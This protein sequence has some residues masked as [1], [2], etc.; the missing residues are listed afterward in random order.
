MLSAWA[1][2]KGLHVLGTGD[3]THP[4]WR[5]ELEEALEPDSASGLYR[6]KDPRGLTREL[7]WLEGYEL[8]GRTLFMLQA[9]I[10]SI[11]KRGGKVRKVHNLVYVPTLEA[12][13]T[14]SEKL[15]AIGNVESDGRPILGLDSRNLLELVLELHPLA[16]LVP[17]HI[18]T[19]W[20][21]LF[22]SKSGFDSLEE[23]FGDLS[24]HVFAMETGL[25]SDPEM[26]WL[27]SALDRIALISNSDAHSGEKLGRE[28]NLFSGER[29][30]EGVY[31]ALR[32]EALGHKL[33]ATL[34]FFPEEGKYHLDGHRKCGV[35]MEPGETLARD[36]R[37]PV[38]GKPLTVGV[39]NRVLTLADRDVPK[40]PPQAAGFES[41]IPLQE[42]ISEVVGTGPATKK[43]RA[44]YARCV[45]R[46]GPELHVLRDA[47]LEDVARISPPLAEALAR[48]RRGEVIRQP[49]FDGQFGVIR[50]FS[51]RERKELHQG[52]FLSAA[53]TAAPATPSR[54]T[55]D[56]A[57][58]APDM[59][60]QTSQAPESSGVVPP[61]AAPALGS[62][63]ASQQAAVA[64]GPGP[65]LVKAGPGS[66]KTHTLLA[67]VA[68]LIEEGVS[69]RRI[70]VVTFTRKAAQELSDRLLARFGELAALP[71]A[72]TLHA[73]AYE[74]WKNAYQDAPVVL[75]EDAARRVFAEANAAESATARELRDAFDRIALARERR[76]APAGTAEEDADEALARW[77]HNFV[78]H[79]ESWNLADYTDLLEFWLEQIEHGIYPRPYVHVLVDEAQDLSRLQIEL[80]RAIVTAQADAQ[81]AVEL[82]AE[83]VIPGRGLFAIGDPDQ[84]I[85]GFR[86]ALPDVATALREIWPHLDVRALERNYRSVQP[87]LDLAA[88][89]L[90]H[91]APLHAHRGVGPALLRLFE[92]PSAES[93]AAWIAERIR[94][95]LGP[96]SHSLADGQTDDE[97]ATLL[98][99]AFSP[100]DI[101]V[102]V[103]TRA[104]IPPLKRVLD[105]MG[106]PVAAPEQETF[107]EDPRVAAILDAAGALFG[108]TR[109]ADA[110]CVDD[111]GDHAPT[112]CAHELPANG[113]RAERDAHGARGDVPPVGTR[114]RDETAKPLPCPDDVLTRGPKAIAAYM[115][116]VPPFDQLFWKSAAFK[117]LVEAFREQG[118]WLGLLNWVHLQS[119]LEHVRRAGEQVQIMTMH[120][121]KG[122]EFRAVFLPALEDGLVPFAG[123]GLAAAPAVAGPDDLAVIPEA[124][125][126]EE[127]RLFYVALTRAKEALFLS[128]AG[129]R[130]LYGRTR[131][132]PAS[133]FLA[134]LVATGLVRRSTLAPKTRTTQ[135]RLSLMD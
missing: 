58:D 55:A 94:R 96:T 27:L 12:A 135:Q 89:S 21:S 26:N 53:P 115:E 69:P 68:R 36:G 125:L 65:V 2:V 118:G 33:Q 105:R 70:L 127:R 66:G 35:A 20:F 31:R 87:V 32:G 54:P 122:L 112:A 108:L 24:Q 45:T 77:R 91:P 119:S 34:E 132:L 59:A 52:T 129:A 95:L 46:L 130:T 11:Y 128:R 37:C 71:R 120:A 22:G 111:A 72:D 61:D 99:K 100:G 103:R 41:L 90:D 81:L 88:T 93:E 51:E 1:L 47:P 60:P 126:A 106:L 49:G 40:K 116:D 86:G 50:V 124:A 28:C 83:P 44:L 43:V 19:P 75:A 114:L 39:L 134:P 17:A 48:M 62:L 123:P 14:L 23:C 67:R 84:S 80:V 8:A 133:R 30:Y 85:Y 121:A 9:E 74:V 79:K 25:S 76:E 4:A 63:D 6:L 98:A 107:W 110:P 109:K 113:A 29:S 73:L 15:A 97:F 102:L 57:S 5:A 131:R 64:A 13:H 18:W 56:D 92:A 7:P 104:V 10:S 78:K 38:C 16:F 3:F 82:E 101:A 117:R 42:V